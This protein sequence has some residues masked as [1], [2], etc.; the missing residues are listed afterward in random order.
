M[1]KSEVIAIIGETG[2]GKSSSLKTLNSE[3]TFIIQIV[4]KPLPFKG[5]KTKYKVFENPSSTPEGNLL[6]TDNVPTILKVFEYI[7]SS[8][9]EIK[10]IVIDDAQYIMSNEFMKR[11]AEKGYDKFTEIAKNMW[12][13]LNKA[14]QLDNDL[15]V[16]LLAHEETVQD[17]NFNTKKKFKTIGKLLDDKITL[18]GLC[19]VVLFADVRE[20]DKKEL[21]YGFITNSDGTTTAKSPFG[22]FEEEFIPNDLQLVIEKIDEYNNG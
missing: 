2:S 4:G 3:E 11:S 1:Y 19:T 12:L 17:A 7:S 14:S 21:T 20:N 5:W 13:I 16:F 18:E 10:Q 22:M 9:P 8:R 6:Q 15:K